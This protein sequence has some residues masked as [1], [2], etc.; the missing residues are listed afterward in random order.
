MRERL[1]NEAHESL[2]ALAGYFAGRDDYESAALCME[3]VLRANRYNEE[4]AYQF[5]QYRSRAG[6]VV[7]ALRFI[8]E[9]SHEYSEEIGEEL[10]ARF[11][12]LRSAIA[13]G[14]AV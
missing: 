14:V 12:D 8:D 13:A 4:A 7:Q 6:Q 3:R 11:W 2:A 5:A 10:P 9:Y 1:E